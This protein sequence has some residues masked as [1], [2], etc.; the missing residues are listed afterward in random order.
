MIQKLFSC[1]GISV[2]ERDVKAE[3]NGS[4]VHQDTLNFPL[5]ESHEYEALKIEIAN[6]KKE[7]K[8]VKVKYQ[9]T[10]QQE[11]FYQDYSTLK[12]QLQDLVH[13]LQ[14]KMKLKES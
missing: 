11:Q 2:S 6:L 1:V 7:L 5:Y 14:T 3:K 4:C 13:T 10:Q 8:E 12:T 9:I